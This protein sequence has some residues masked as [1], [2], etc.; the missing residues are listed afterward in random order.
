[1]NA[2]IRL[3]DALALVTAGS[4]TLLAACESGVGPDGPDLTSEDAAAIAGF[5]SEVEHV[6]LGTLSLAGTSGSR[7]FTWTA[8]CPAGGSVTVAGSGESS[9][10]QEKRVVST[11]WSTTKTSAACA[12]SRT[13]GDQTLTAV[14]DGKV[15]TSGA[16][17]YQLPETRGEAR[18]LLSWSSATV[19][20]TTT[21]VGDRSN[22]CAVD[23][24]ETYDPAAKTF[25]VVGT[26]CGREVNLT[27]GLNR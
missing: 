13:R 11:R 18:T 5:F 24:K 23:L 14:V 16:A 20:S 8:P 1:M 10:N 19:G 17:S 7:T 27:R 2:T 26:M 12:V 25:T 22:T 6:S 15:T 4:L 9:T 21:K 3:R